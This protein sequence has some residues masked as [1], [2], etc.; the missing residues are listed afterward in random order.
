[1]DGIEITLEW[2]A[3]EITMNDKAKELLKKEFQHNW[4]KAIVA[5]SLAH[6]S[7]TKKKEFLWAGSRAIGYRECCIIVLALSPGGDYIVATGEVDQWAAEIELK[8]GLQLI[9]S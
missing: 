3:P 9:C 4:E 8:Y 7:P 6:Q 5:K 1:M 2:D